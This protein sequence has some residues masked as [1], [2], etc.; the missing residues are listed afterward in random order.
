MFPEP[1]PTSICKNTKCRRRE[2]ELKSGFM[3][4]P[5]REMAPRLSL[6]LPFHCLLFSRALVFTPSTIMS[7]PCESCFLEAYTLMG[8]EHSTII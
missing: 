8:L 7:G 3:S 6:N 2:N 1:S 5:T 4:A